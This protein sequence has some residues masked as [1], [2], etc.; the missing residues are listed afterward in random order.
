MSDLVPRGRSRPGRN[1][2]FSG[3]P[4][5]TREEACVAVVTSMIDMNNAAN[6]IRA[7][8]MVQATGTFTTW[9]M[10]WKLGVSESN[11]RYW[12]NGTAVGQANS[13]LDRKL[14]LTRLYDLVDPRY[15]YTWEPLET[16][17]EQDNFIGQLEGLAQALRE[18]DENELQDE[19]RDW[20][21]AEAGDASPDG[22]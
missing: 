12:I 8:K 11:F 3:P 16:S 9:F 19:D 10:S 20:D 6:F 17:Q 7:V 14:I 18:A 22:D 15:Y 13:R 21:G 5:Y 1:R 2:L 4:E